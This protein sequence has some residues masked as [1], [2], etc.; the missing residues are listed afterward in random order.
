MVSET[1]GRRVAIIK[2]LAHPTRLQIAE[3][4]FDGPRCV[5]DLHAETG[6]DLSTVSKHLNLM[7]EAGWIRC[8]K[9][10]LQVFYELAC[11]CFK[12]FLN[13]VDSL[14]AA[15]SDSDCC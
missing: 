4:L 3:S 9:K 8:E 10:G 6:F 13:C 11:P 7:R 14:V 1:R 15:A 2:A 5:S 12:V